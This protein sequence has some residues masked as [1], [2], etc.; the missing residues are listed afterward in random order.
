MIHNSLEYS[1][2]EKENIHCDSYFLSRYSEQRE[3]VQQNR[4]RSHI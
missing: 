2:K 1:I 3:H 4:N